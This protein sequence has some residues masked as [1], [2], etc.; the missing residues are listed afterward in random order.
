MNASKAGAVS[1]LLGAL[2]FGCEDRNAAAVSEGATGPN[3]G[4]VPATAAG[5]Q[6]ALMRW[7]IV[8]INFA[9]GTASAGGT[10][11]DFANDNSKITLTGS[12]TFRSNSGKS[13]N[14][15]GGGTWAIDAPAGSGTYE[16][17]G[18][19]SYVLAPGTFPLPH[20]NIGNPADARSGL[21]VLKISY[22]DG[23][24]GVLIVSC[25]FIGTPDAVFE[26]VT[27]SKGFVDYWRPDVPIAGVDGNRTAFHVIN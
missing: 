24:D 22:D 26:G 4:T 1:A 27:A 14:V 23:S 21:A 11:S 9:T 25:H 8:S 18:F 17:T 13:Q 7:D 15:T 12:G 16:V 5:S 2:L 10:A 19:V 3:A 20:D 6:N